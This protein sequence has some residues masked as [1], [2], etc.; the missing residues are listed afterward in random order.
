MYA[1]RKLPYYF[2]AYTVMVLTQLPLQALLQKSD[3]TS[4]IAKWGTKLGAYDVKYMPQIGIKGQVLAGFMAEFTEGTVSEEEKALGVMHTLAMVIPLWEV[5][6][7]GAAN[8][9]GARIRIVLITPEKLV[10]EKSLRLG[11]LATNNGAEYE[12]L[13]VGVALVSQLGREVVEF[14]S[15]S[16]FVVG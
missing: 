5:Y 8:Q 6:I 13:L 14:Y 15:N 4:R 3:Y 7:D 1:T 2:Q 10:M 9:K 16:W 11:F 12:A